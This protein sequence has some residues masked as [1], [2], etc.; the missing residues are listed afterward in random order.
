MDSWELKMIVNDD[1]YHLSS[2]S[3]EEINSIWYSDLKLF[4]FLFHNGHW[5]E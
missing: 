3:D 5:E 1:Y 2:W 4:D